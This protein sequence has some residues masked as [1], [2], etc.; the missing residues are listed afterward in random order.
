M[1]TLNLAIDQALP[2]M[3]NRHVAGRLAAPPRGGA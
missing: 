3:G 1:T 2:A